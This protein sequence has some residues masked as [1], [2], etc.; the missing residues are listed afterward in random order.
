M[1]DLDLTES[2]RPKSDQLD[3]VDLLTG[4]RTF[5]IERVTKGN[6]EQPFNY[7]LAEFPRPW[8]PGKSMRRVL[9]ALWGKDAAAHAGRRLTLFCDP[10]VKFGGEA[11]GGVRISHMSH[12]D[13]P[14]SV[15][16]IVT[17]GRSATFRVDPLPDDAPTETLP[18]QLATLTPDDIAECYDLDQLRDWHRT[19]T[20]ELREHITTRANQLKAQEAGQ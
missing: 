15:P 9:L 2:T 5:T 8:R 10:T 13:K 1:T 6:A 18:E 3:A 11:V 16:L 14:K 17:R 19:A 4:P 12:I 7:H 20:P